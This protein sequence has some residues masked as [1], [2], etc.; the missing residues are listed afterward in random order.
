MA[1]MSPSHGG[2]WVLATWWG[3]PLLWLW[4]PFRAGGGAGPLGHLLEISGGLGRIRGWAA[5]EERGDEV[6]LRELGEG[7]AAAYVARGRG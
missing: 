4:Q 7:E 2:Y 1:T 6:T 5:M 3:E